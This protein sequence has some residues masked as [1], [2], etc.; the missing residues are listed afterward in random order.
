MSTALLDRDTRVA[1]PRAGFDLYRDALAVAGLYS[2][3][4][5]Q[6]L[7]LVQDAQG[8]HVV[9]GPHPDS[10]SADTLHRLLHAFPRTAQDVPDIGG[11][12]ERLGAYAVNTMGID[13]QDVPGVLGMAVFSHTATDTHHDHVFGS[14]SSRHLLRRDEDEEEAPTVF[15]TVP[16]VSGTAVVAHTIFD[17]A[18]HIGQA[19]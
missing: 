18:Y 19:S 13:P 1:A 5:Q 8:V 6:P 2:F 7:S 3:A 14:T 16:N 11:A 9:M 12:F 4:T 10:E 17:V 15:V